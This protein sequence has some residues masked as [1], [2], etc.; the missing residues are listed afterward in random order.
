MS[1]T[2]KNN[3][4]NEKNFYNSFCGRY[5]HLGTYPNDINQLA[6]Q[7]ALIMTQ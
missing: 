3:K 7:A 6:Q 1:Q 2:W 4:S 5:M